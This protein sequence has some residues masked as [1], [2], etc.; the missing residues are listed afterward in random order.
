MSGPRSTRGVL[1]VLD[2]WGHSDETA[3]NALA[4]ARTPTLDLLRS[5]YPSTLLSAAGESVGLLPGTVGNSEIGHLV[6]GAGRPLPY[7][8][9]L[10]QQRIDSGELRA[11]QQLNALAQRVAQNDKA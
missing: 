8:S 5:K 1:L 10:V 9:L 4:Q 6:I 3:G 11:D 2:G 7:D